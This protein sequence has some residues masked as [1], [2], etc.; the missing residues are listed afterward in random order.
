M[1]SKARTSKRYYALEESHTS[2]DALG[3]TIRFR[4][5]IFRRGEKRAMFR[6]ATGREADEILRRLNN[7]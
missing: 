1:T 2:S 7:A 6:T 3:N 5:A 4:W